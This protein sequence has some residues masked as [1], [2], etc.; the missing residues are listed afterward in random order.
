MNGDNCKRA[1]IIALDGAG[2]AIKDVYAPNI[3]S[4]FKK[5]YLTYMAETSVPSSS[6]ECYG[7]LFHG[8]SPEKHGIDN[9]RAKRLPF[10]EDSAYPSFMKL[11]RQKW[12]DCKLASFCGWEPI[13]LGII[14]QS[15]QVYTISDSDE[16]VIKKS[17]EYIKN[18]D[19]KILF[20]Q[21]EG[22][23]SAGHTYGYWTDQFYEKIMELDK[24]LGDIFD[25]I[26]STGYINESLVIVCSDHGGG[27]EIF[28]KHGS[29]H[30]KD[31]TIFWGCY[32]PMIELSTKLKRQINIKDT[33]AV[34]AW[35]LDLKIPDTWEG[36]VPEEWR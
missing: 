6:G 31:T 21:L 24:A 13:N 2:N 3:N 4:F 9:G 12:P 18:E 22:P 35:S 8:V 16:E 23:D 33:A 30:P 28:N 19:F 20:I 11:A 26:I 27:G 1:I 32:N 10:P 7:S 34:V 17:I 25:A 36:Q 14:E 15:A 5:G 29:G